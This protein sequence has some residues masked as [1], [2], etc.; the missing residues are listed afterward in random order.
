MRETFYFAIYNVQELKEASLIH[1]E[2]ELVFN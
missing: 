2:K 1:Q